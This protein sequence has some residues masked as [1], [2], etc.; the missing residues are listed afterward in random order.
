MKLITTHTG[1]GFDALAAML[2]ARRLHPEARLVA[3]CAPEDRVRDYL[4]REGAGLP[5]FLPAED[6]RPAEIRELI[7]VDARSA[8]GLGP[9]ADFA[10]NAA[11]RGVTIRVYDRHPAGA[12]DLEAAEIHGGDAAATSGVVA[13]RLEE[14]GIVPEP[15]EATLL[16]SGI[17]EA[18]GGL[19]SA[20]VTPGDLRAAAWLIEAGADRDA[21]ARRLERPS[22]DARRRDLLDRLR[23]QGWP[24]VIQG[25]R[26]V[27]TRLDEPVDVDEA[28]SLMRDAMR[29]GDMDA[30]FAF[31]TVN[32]AS[33]PRPHLFCRSAAPEINVGLLVRAFREGREG[34][35]D[36]G[37]AQVA[38]GDI[39]RTE[40]EEKLLGL[41][42][43]GVR[44]RVRAGDLM[45]RPAVAVSAEVTLEE[46]AELLTRYNFTVLPVVERQAEAEGQAPSGLLGM[47]SRGVVEKA[48]FHDLGKARVADYMTTDIAALTEESGIADIIGLIVGRR[49]RLAPVRRGRTLAGV[50]TRTDLLGL[51]L[52]DPDN[53]APDLIRADAHPSVKRGRNLAELMAERLSRESIVLL[54]EIGEIAQ[55]RGCQAFVAGGFVR[56][57]LLGRRNMDIDI[58][59]EGD[60]IGFAQALV[61]ARG[62]LA[63]PHRK[64]NT[65]TVILPDERRID[66]ASARLEHYERPVAL[67]TVERGSIKRDLH[68][69][70]FTINAMAIYLN[71]DRFGTLADFYNSQDDLEARR[72]QVLHNLS[73]VEDPTRIYRAVRFE[74]RLGFR[75]SPNSERLIR[76]AV[77]L[78]LPRRIDGARC[79]HELVMILSEDNPIP[80]LLRMEDFGLFTFLW[81]GL[82]PDFKLGRRARHTLAMTRRA[83]AWYR[84]LRPDAALEA[85]RVYL[86]ALTCRSSLQEL[87]ELCARLDMPERPRAFLLRQKQQ[88]EETARALFRRPGLPNSACYWLFRELA[89][90]GLLYLEAIARRRAVKERV[91]RYL[92]RLRDMKPLLD[93][94]AL[95]ALGYRPGP[96]FAR[97]QRRLLEAQ[98]DGRVHDAAE[99]RALVLAEFPP[100]GTPEAPSP[101]FP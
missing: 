87:D 83:L 20:S 1:A 72:I 32:E 85:W 8:A 64:F 48:I 99:A 37:E 28:R 35:G 38:L 101:R 65:A 78:G 50:I 63:H 29:G 36:A 6:L 54:R 81:P 100:D 26:L 75:I 4:A 43:D 33:G 22:P 49:Q 84:L 94:A 45:S 15:W 42:Q 31:L 55:A 23:R 60:G 7:L 10:R 39:D 73:F 61:Q 34:G 17:H 88:A 98:I 52:N 5:P 41:L 97:M 47:I 46:A 76:N 62:G 2:A 11:A 67:P 59:V 93:G 58:V 18:S 69:R 30:L 86:L 89:D 74:A 53:V 96:R 24:Y 56:D 71:P 25:Q 91:T 16:L 3:L 27:V 44:P 40:A 68:R 21:A 51:L 12:D 70:D 13:R 95:K 80:A 19:A 66:V 9:L 92:S 90:E 77:R 14:A 79:L 82:K 57:L